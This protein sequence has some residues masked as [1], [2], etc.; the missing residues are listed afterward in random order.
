MKKIYEEPQAVLTVIPA[1]NILAA[2]LEILDAFFGE[3]DS[4]MNE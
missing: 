2:S 1:E 3:E 4:L